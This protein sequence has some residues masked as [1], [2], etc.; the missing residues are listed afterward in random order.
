MPYVS[1]PDDIAILETVY[2]IYRKQEQ[3]TQAMNVAIR[4]ND[5]EKM[6]DCVNSC[7]DEYPLLKDDR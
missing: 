3:I 2:A 4:L 5:R 6:K 7:Q 1:T